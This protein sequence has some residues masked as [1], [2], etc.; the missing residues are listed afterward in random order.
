MNKLNC[1]NCGLEFK[2]LRVSGMYCS[3][4]CRKRESRVSVTDSNVVSVTNLSVTPKEEVSVTE[5]KLTKPT[6][7]CHGCKIQQSDSDVCICYICIGKK[8]THDSLGL[9]MCVV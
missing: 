8:T 1:R 9:R 7:L 5:F 3:S 2:P 6:G 4:S